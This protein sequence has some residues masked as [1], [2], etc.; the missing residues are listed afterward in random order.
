MQTIDPTAIARHSR[1]VHARLLDSGLPRAGPGS[2]TWTINR[3]MVVV[4]AWGRAILL[5]LAHP[6][7]A[8]ALEHHSTFRGSI[9]AA[10]SRLRLTIRA[11]L[12][13]TFGDLE[14][15][16][17]AAARINAIHD[18]VRAAGYSAHDAALQR[19]VHATLLVS[20]LDT[21]ERLVG[22]LTCDQRNRYCAEAAI[23]EPMLG[24]PSG[25]LPRSSAELTT[26]ME[27]MLAGNSL[28]ITES[29]RA[30]A[31]AVLSPPRWY[32]AWPAFRPLQLM[33][34]GSLPDRI[35]RAYGFAWRPRDER[36]LA[37]W[38]T[39]IR[40]L[41]RFVPRIAR[42]WPISGSARRA[43]GLRSRSQPA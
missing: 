2:V 40:V 38:T 42:E 37:R 7:I 43:S 35:R 32:L 24:L 20:T 22:P 9:G 21:Y 3:E 17:A 5:Q 16:I 12:L 13:I 6:A 19:W 34:I 39:T 27:D 26:Y 33:T 29:S 8:S 4:A 10:L 30:L 28:H 18:H 15:M 31:R 36:A 23:M 25:L 14:R 41:L 1:A 11:M